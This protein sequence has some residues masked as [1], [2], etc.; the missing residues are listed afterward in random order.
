MT[1]P[2]LH[3]ASVLKALARRRDPYWGAPIA[4]GQHVGYRKLTGEGGT[5]IARYRGEDKKMRFRSL[6]V[7]SPN[8]Q[9]DQAKAAASEWFASQVGPAWNSNRDVSVADACREYV[10]TKKETFEAELK[11][12]GNI[13]ETDQPA[14]RDA[15]S[16][17]K[18]TIYSNPMG[19]RPAAKITT[20]E[21]K[22]WRAD[23]G[24]SEV[25]Q[26]RTMTSLRAALNHAVENRRLPVARRIE[27]DNVKQH[28][29]VTDRKLPFLDLQQRKAFLDAS[30]EGDF[31][32]FALAHILTGARPGELA[33]MRRR[34]FDAR[35]KSASLIGKTSKKTGAR[36][37]PLSDE[38]TSLFS[39]RSQSLTGDDLL[40]TNQGVKWKHYEW[41][42]Y[43]RAAA[44]S[45]KSPAGT[46]LYCFR[47][48]W[49][50]QSLLDGMPAFQVAKL[51][52]T[53]LAMIEKHY[54]HLVTSRARE[55]LNRVKYV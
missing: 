26:N 2:Q 4:R 20:A 21:I 35:T 28:S 46:V 15:E 51:T 40:F 41:D 48:S 19:A 53:S 54:G 55:E 9:F 47:H 36:T 12:R 33:R 3:K 27:W 8:F 49:I 42:A 45:A 7:A 50:T 1:T 30:G 25:S 38:A 44:N 14:W 32:D 23:L 31:H 10:K 22:R 29:C 11:H 43:V 6:G 34:Q 52:G 5:W 24:L 13:A 16:R 18:R 39:R 37:V 17:F